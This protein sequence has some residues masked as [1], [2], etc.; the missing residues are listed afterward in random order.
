[1]TIDDN[2]IKHIMDQIINIERN[3]F[4]VVSIS[5][6]GI[7]VFFRCSKCRKLVSKNHKQDHKIK[8]WGLYDTK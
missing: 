2:G 5:S 1:M 7:P 6:T 8:C 3:N 4:I